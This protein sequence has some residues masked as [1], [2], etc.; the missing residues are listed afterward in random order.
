MTLDQLEKQAILSA[1]SICGKNKTRTAQALGIAIRTLDNKFEKYAEDDKL[2]EASRKQ[3]IKR[4]D[5][6]LEIARNGR[7]KAKPEVTPEMP[8]EPKK[9][10]AKAK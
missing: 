4:G 10:A 9:V 2:A 5:D 3:M 6:Y 8:V 7:P 1:Y